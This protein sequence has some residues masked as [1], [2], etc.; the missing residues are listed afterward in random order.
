MKWKKLVR[1]NVDNRDRIQISADIKVVADTV[2]EA[3]LKLH[4][5]LLDADAAI[6]DGNEVANPKIVQKYEYWN[7]ENEGDV[8][9]T[10]FRNDNTFVEIENVQ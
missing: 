6:T 1:E 4:N 3:V 9:F 2:E 7:K 5:Q 10:L 8:Q